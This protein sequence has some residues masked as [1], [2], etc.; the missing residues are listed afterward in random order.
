[1]LLRGLF[2]AA[3]A[4][5]E[6]ADVFVA[7]DMPPPADPRRTGSPAS[8]LEWRELGRWGRSFVATA[9][10]RSE[11]AAF[12]GPAAMAP[13]RVYV[14][15]RSAET[16]RERAEL[17]LAELIRAGGF[18]RSTLVVVAPVGTGWMDPG[19][20]TRSTSCSAATWRRWRCS[21]RT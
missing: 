5:F 15:R 9:P 4:S 19:A 8:L 10:S 6:A 14:R 16:P 13:V 18:E 7:P 11:I 12:A 3:D 21:I 1:M 2:E 17:A 20:M